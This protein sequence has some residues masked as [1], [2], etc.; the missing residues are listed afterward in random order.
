[1]TDRGDIL[2]ERDD[3]VHMRSKKYE[4]KLLVKKFF[5]LLMLPHPIRKPAMIKTALKLKPKQETLR[6]NLPPESFL[7]KNFF[8]KLCYIGTRNLE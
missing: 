7:L 4:K 1:M 3:F 6:N 2:I 5:K 8:N